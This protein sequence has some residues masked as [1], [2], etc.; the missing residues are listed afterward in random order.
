MSRKSLSNSTTSSTTGKMN[1]KSKTK[2]QSEQKDANTS[3]ANADTE[4]TSGEED[5][6]WV[7][8]GTLGPFAVTIE[9]DHQVHDDEVFVIACAVAAPPT[10]E[11]SSSSYDQLVRFVPPQGILLFD[12]QN[13]T[14]GGY[15]QSYFYCSAADLGGAVPSSS[16]S[17]ER[18]TH[19]KNK[20]NHNHYHQKLQYVD[21]N[22]LPPITCRTFDG[23]D[24]KAIAAGG[25]EAIPPIATTHPSQRMMNGQKHDHHQ[26]NPH[27]TLSSSSSRRSPST[28]SHKKHRRTS[29]YSS[30]DDNNSWNT[31]QISFVML[32]L[33]GIG[34]YYYEHCWRIRT[35]TKRTNTTN[36]TTNYKTHKS[37]IKN[38][39]RDKI[40]NKTKNKPPRH[41]EEQW[42]TCIWRIMNRN[43]NRNDD[44]IED[45]NTAHKENKNN[46][47]NT[48]I[49]SFRTTNINGSRTIFHR[50]YTTWSGRRNHDDDHTTDNEYADA[51]LDFVTSDGNSGTAD[52]QQ[53]NGRIDTNNTTS[54]KLRHTT[55]RMGNNNRNTSIIGSGTGSC[56]SSSNTNTKNVTKKKKNT[57]DDIVTTSDNDNN[58]N[59]NNNNFQTDDDATITSSRRIS[60][61]GTNSSI[62]KNNMDKDEDKYHKEKS[63]SIVTVPTI[64]TS[65]SNTATATADDEKKDWK[66]NNNSN[67]NDEQEEDFVMVRNGN[68]KSTNQHHR[69]VNIEEKKKKDEDNCSTTAGNN[70]I[71]AKNPNN[72]SNDTAD[73]TAASDVTGDNR[74]KPSSQLLTSSS[75]TTTT[76]MSLLTK[77]G[78]SINKNKNSSSIVLSIDGMSCGGCVKIVNKTLTAFDCIDTVHT[79]L[80]SCTSTIMY[81]VERLKLLPILTA[82]D[83][84]GMEAYLVSQQSLLSSSSSSSSSS[85]QQEHGKD[86]DD[87]ERTYCDNS[88]STQQA[89]AG[90]YTTPDQLLPIGP[91]VIAPVDEG[92]QPSSFGGL[93][94]S[95]LSLMDELRVGSIPLLRRYKCSC[96][97][98]GCICSSRQVHKNDTGTDVSLTDLCN[99]LVDQEQ[100]KKEK[101]QQIIGK[102]KNPASQSLVQQHQTSTSL[103]FLQDATNLEAS[104]R[105]NG[106]SEELR[107]KLSNLS[108]PCGC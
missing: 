86:Q 13:Y 98:E 64:T 51:G 89:S 40:K 44:T 27:D 29:D 15:L 28:G 93:S 80:K 59:N 8:G 48:T 21:P 17:D 55:P 52:P 37:K 38:K 60:C 72:N 69:N 34:W 4:A 100:K 47:N 7:L 2:A 46:S 9:P 45:L 103:L 97:C 94:S 62:G 36:N 71:C 88:T 3:I 58:N 33:G 23:E 30:S 39:M 16:S 19:N 74:L 92:P 76:T 14:L 104:F 61:S 81:T 108:F 18:T 70:K 63:D 26:K 10:E 5:G 99:R 49:R 56:T 35:M 95:P 107:Q 77:E 90:D 32:V 1:T 41:P 87:K 42:R 91:A 11:W 83:E 6:V 67:N 22:N 57:H 78:T 65:N 82:L 79:D 54:S 68:K 53:Q 43:R 66:T 50:I 20:N 96:G 25:R 84:L 12:A 75:S 85:S 31:N 73:I 105:D 101:E 102:E 106:G 24:A